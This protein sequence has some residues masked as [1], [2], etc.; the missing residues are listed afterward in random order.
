MNPKVSFIVPCYRLGHLLAECVQSILSQ[1]YTDFEVLIMDDCSPDN[2]PEVGSSFGDARVRYVRNE[3]NLGHLRNYNKG[4]GLAQGE[5]IWLISADDRLR[6]DYVL[7]RYVSLMDAH[8]EIGYA[9][10]PGHGLH[11]SNDTGLL[12][13]TAYRP[14]DAILN[15]RQFLNDLLDDNFILAP[16]GMVRRQCYEQL[17]A[18]PED[19]PYGGDWYLWC[20]FALHYDVGYFAEP[21]VDYRIHDLSMTN[22]LRQQNIRACVEDDLIL[23]WR[24]RRE[25]ERVGAIAVARRAR[26][27]IAEQFS[28]ALV[29]FSVR[30]ATSSISL[31]DFEERLGRVCDNLLEEAEIASQVFEL[32]GDRFYWRNEFA[33]SREMYW[34]ARRGRP[35]SMVVWAKLLL[36]IAGKPGMTIRKRISSVRRKNDTQPQGVPA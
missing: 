11:D 25:A 27:A 24:I 34:R 33:R 28:R 14:Q 2:T 6:C 31:N 10:C 36:S 15:G 3:P 35:L 17:G 7:Q 32:A 26:R 20:L 22:A 21:M 18:F 23:P 4:I 5:Y 1:T 9:F 8:P 13:W 19:M 16:S 30:G 29:S 12:K